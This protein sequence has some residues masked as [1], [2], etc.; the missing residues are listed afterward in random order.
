MQQQR[1]LLSLVRFHLHRHRLAII[2]NRRPTRRGDGGYR[3]VTDFG[4]HQTINIL[5]SQTSSQRV[6][7]ALMNT[8]GILFGLQTKR[9][10]EE[11]KTHTHNSLLTLPHQRKD[12]LWTQQQTW[13]IVVPSLPLV[14]APFPCRLSSSSSSLGSCPMPPLGRLHPRPVPRWIRKPVH[15]ELTVC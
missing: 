5:I 2:R 11:L 10:F 14:A 3:C 13:F 12:V 1:L 8:A 4:Q 6:S 7:I 15:H 9:D